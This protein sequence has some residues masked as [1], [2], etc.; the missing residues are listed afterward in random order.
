MALV[1]LSGTAAKAQVIDFTLT[2]PAYQTAAP[3]AIVAFDATVSDADP[4]ADVYLNSDS[5]SG[6]LPVDDGPFSS[7]P[8][9]LGPPVPPDATS[10][11]TYTGLLFNVAV[12]LGTPDGSYSGSFAI[13]GGS[14]SSA[15]DTLGAVDFTVQV[16]TVPEGGTEAIYLLLAAAICFGALLFVRRDQTAR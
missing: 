15:G 3:G 16:T 2:S 11:I 1:L 4:S 13:Q 8:V 5:T 12:P 10:V 14:D 6:A 7:F 9:Y